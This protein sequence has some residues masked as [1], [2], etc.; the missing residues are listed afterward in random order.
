MSEPLRVQ[1]SSLMNKKG[2]RKQEHMRVGTEDR[3]DGCTVL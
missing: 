2:L 3:G 1:E